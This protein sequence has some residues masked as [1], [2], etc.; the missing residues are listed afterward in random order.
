MKKLNKFLTIIYIFV[1]CFNFLPSNILHAANIELSTWVKEVIVPSG[2]LDSGDVLNIEITVNNSSN[3]ERE[4][5]LQSIEFM[6]G[7]KCLG[8][9]TLGFDLAPGVEDISIIRKLE[10]KG[11]GNRTISYS[12]KY[13]EKT[14]SGAVTT[15][16]GTIE[17][18]KTLDDS[19]IVVDTKKY[20]PRISLVNDEI[21]ELGAGE[22]KKVNLPFVNAG[23]FTAKN[24]TITV[25]ANK[26][27]VQIPIL[28]KDLEKLHFSSINREGV[29]HLSFGIQVDRTAKPGLYPITIKY[30]YT[31]SSDDEF[32]N[33]DTVYVKV[34]N[35]QMPARIQFGVKSNSPISPG[36]PASLEITATNKGQSPAS[37]VEISLSGL[38]KDGLTV[39]EGSNTSYIPSI[40][41]GETKTTQ[42]KVLASGTLEGNIEPLTIEYTYSDGTT[43]IQ[44]STQEIFVSL[45]GKTLGLSELSIENIVTPGN[46]VGTGEDFNVSFSLINNSKYPAKSVKITLDGGEILKP[47][48]Q[49]IYAINN[50]NAGAK[51]NFSAV[52]WAGSDAEYRN[53]PIEIKVEYIPYQGAGVATFSQYVGINVAGDKSNAKSKPRI[54]IGE[55]TVEPQIVRA[56]QEFDL[57]IGFTNT[58]SSKTVENMK[59]V[60]TIN[61][62]GADNTTQDTGTVFT[63]VSGQSN[64]FYLAEINPGETVL[65]NVRMYTVPDANPKTYEVTVE[66]E[67]EDSIGEPY[68]E[69]AKIGIPVQQSTQIDVGEVRIDGEAMIG[70][71]ISVI[72]QIFNTGRTNIKNL[73]VTVEGPF[74]K[75]DANFFVGNFVQG[76]EEYYEGIVIP[77]QPGECSGELVVIYEEIT[78]E[79]QEQRLSFTML[80]MDAPSFDEMEMGPDGMGMMPPEIEN[81]QKPFYKNPITWI[82]VVLGLALAA[83]TIIII[84][85]KRKRNE[86]SLDE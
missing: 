73:M 71:P 58:H 6:D 31:N 43:E 82:G 5:R 67:Y 62:K 11:G 48:S 36:K 72:S 40:K 55:Y 34:L 26:E 2:K 7:Y 75:E 61:E 27:G 63:P 86:M 35:T 80:V 60:L 51:K 18:S 8:S 56:G 3:S 64:M 52:F 77:T 45:D 1:F 53:Y 44:K 83:A 39:V 85:K 70:R 66:M 59:A 78:G 32:E 12:I 68:T 41:V 15:T 19:I 54:I 81:Q 13:A 16:T 69:V 74:E 9:T 42:F 46:S 21:V 84:M 38:K 76:S 24:L 47:K 37:N 17:G 79:K 25:E 50:F 29:N 33:K 65:K 28:I 23:G 20:Q 22:Y 14:E 57:S 4:V 49:S 10:Y 30:K